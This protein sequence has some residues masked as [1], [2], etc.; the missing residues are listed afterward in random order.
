MTIIERFNVREHIHHGLVAGDIRRLINGFHL[1]RTEKTLHWRVV[2]PGAHAIH[3]D[4]ETMRGQQ[5]LIR[6]TGVL[7][8]VV[9][10]AGVLLVQTRSV[11]AELVE[12]VDVPA[13]VI[14]AEDDTLVDISHAE[15]N[16]AGI[17]GS[18]LV[19]YQTGG[20]LQLGNIADIQVQ[21]ENFLKQLD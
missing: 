21:V 2:V 19:K 13:L 16:A 20:H 15:H 17:K 10:F 8:P 9:R 7:A 6:P 5:C 3:T 4:H 18:V 11:P 12:M 14:H 1:Q